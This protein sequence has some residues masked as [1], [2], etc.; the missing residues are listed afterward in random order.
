MPPSARQPSSHRKPGRTGSGRQALGYADGAPVQRR[1]FRYGSREFRAAS[2]LARRLPDSSPVPAL[3]GSVVRQP[4]TLRILAAVWRLPVTD[5]RVRQADADAW[6]FRHWFGPRRRLAW[7]V[8]D[9]PAAEGHYLVGRPKQALRTNLRHARALGM[10]SSRVSYETWFE[11]VSAIMRARG[12]KPGPEQDGPG[13]GQQ[14]A[15]YVTRDACGTPLAFAGVALFGQFAALF[16]LV[17]R[18][19]RQPDASWARYHLHTFLA[20]DL[21][22]S[23][24]QYLLTGSA[25][26]E[27]PGHQYF[28]HLL[29]YRARNVRV[30]VTGDAAVTDKAVDLV[31][32]SS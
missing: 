13:P 25:L 22:R 31:G 19:D 9:L 26:R 21:G 4:S 7:A 3:L 18:P 11:A 5:L 23:G 14:A 27:P 17:S 29:G 1:E 2:D 20:L 16:S 6:W 10:T 24:V 28:Q 15:Y 8:L 32:L 30:K 12:D